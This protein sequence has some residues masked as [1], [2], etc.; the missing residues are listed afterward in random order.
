MAQTIQK[1]TTSILGIIKLFIKAIFIIPRAQTNIF[2]LPYQMYS[3]DLFHKIGANR[4]SHFIGIPLNLIA[5]YCIFIP[6][7]TWLAV[8][9]IGVVFAH[10]LTMTIKYKLYV[11]IPILVLFHSI[12]AGLAFFVFEPYVFV[13]S[14]WYLN[15]IF[16]FVFWPF[17]QYVTHS[18]EPFIPRP[19]SI[20]GNWTAMMDFMKKAP[21]GKKILLVFMV[22]FHTFVELVSS[23]RNLYIE[24]LVFTN[25]LGYEPPVLKETINWINET[26]NEE[27]PV[28]DY[29]DF[30]IAFQ[31]VLDKLEEQEQ[32]ANMEVSV[33]H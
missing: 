11:M 28:Y 18:L 22:P 19:W 25:K 26:I 8:A 3:F 30:T 10:H 12:F 14:I 31:P 21:L 1:E 24:L 23:W 2:D 6:I 17:V 7:N 27:D 20:K 33:S 13:D 9:A 5:L 32:A 4:W 16:H 15:P 29:S